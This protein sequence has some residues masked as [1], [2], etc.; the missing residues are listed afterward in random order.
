MVNPVSIWLMLFLG[1]N[2]YAAGERQYF[3]ADSLKQRLNSDSYNRNE[4]KQRLK[5]MGSHPDQ[6]KMLKKQKGH[7][8][9]LPNGKYVRGMMLPNNKLSPALI[10]EGK[11]VPAC[12]I[13]QTF[14]LVAGQWNSQHQTIECEVEQFKLALISDQ[15]QISV[16]GANPSRNKKINKN[17]AAPRKQVT[18]SKNGGGGIARKPSVNSDIYIPP[19]VGGGAKTSA[20]GAVLG[21]ANQKFGITIGT[22]A[23]CRLERGV[24]S[25]ESG[26]IEIKL[27]EALFG[28][29]KEIPAGTT[30]FASKRIN[31]ATERLEAFVSKALTPD[32]LEYDSISATIFSLDKSAGLNGELVRD[33][34]GELGSAASNATLTGVA[35]AM[36][37]VTG[38]VG[39]AVVNS[40]TSDMINTEQKYSQKRPA[41]T[42]NVSPQNCLIKITKSF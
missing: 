6:L 21:S 40:F 7:Y 1:C 31:M 2:A 16:L 14:E 33:R 5:T 36:P 42:I 34:E 29:Y 27:Q 17:S 32:E 38:D 24:S 39:G 26:L 4:S 30:L 8:Y 41:A 25:S 11:D 23:K 13:D 9:K 18:I 28:K 37:S 35:A 20:I 22:W 12:V 15:K 19:F 10:V 3:T